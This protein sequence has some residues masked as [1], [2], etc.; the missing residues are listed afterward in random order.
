MF[1]DKIAT[2]GQNHRFEISG[3]GVTED[4]MGVFRMDEQTGV[5][6]ALQAIDRETYSLFHVR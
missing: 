5:V 1:N 3:M 6:E 4:P 2:V